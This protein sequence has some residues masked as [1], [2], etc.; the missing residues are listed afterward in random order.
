MTNDQCP[1]TKK[2]A[3]RAGFEPAVPCG[4]QTFQACTFGHSDTSPI[5]LEKGRKY[6]IMQRALLRLVNGAGNAAF[7]SQIFPTFVLNYKAMSVPTT[8]TAANH[9]SMSTFGKQPTDHM[10]IAEYKNGAWSKGSLKSFQKLLM[11][12]FALCFHYGQTIFEGMKAFQMQ[13]GQ[14][15]IFRPDKHFERINISLERMC[16]PEL[17]K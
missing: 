16:M 2:R 5:S 11:S 1:M 12:P 8:L 14:V 17:S 4:T 6:N 13:D 7:T 9:A 3:E 15:N 10:F